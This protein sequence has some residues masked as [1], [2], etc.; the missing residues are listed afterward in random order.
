[1]AV[2]S[3]ATTAATP[4]AWLPTGASWLTSP[5]VKT[6]TNLKAGRKSGELQAADFK[7]DARAT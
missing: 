4:A 3:P 6:K 7:R 5:A 2:A 1:M